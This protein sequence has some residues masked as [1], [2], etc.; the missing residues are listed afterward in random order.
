M[1]A[2][3]VAD[4]GSI[5]N[6]VEQ[7]AGV[8]QSLGQNSQQILNIVE[9]IRDIADRTNLLALNAAIEAARAGE[10]GR[11][12][13][14]VAD[15]VRKL[16]EQTRTSTQEI[17]ATVDS[18][19][20][21]THLAVDKMSGVSR[22]V[23]EGAARA[24]QAGLALDEIDHQIESSVTWANDIAHSTSEQQVV[25]ERFADTVLRIHQLAQRNHGASE[26]SDLAARE[27]IAL[28][29]RLT[30]VVQKFKL[31]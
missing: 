17:S 24:K 16:A 30:E 13:A 26:N 14:V 9:V 23:G 5:A 8:V 25:T 22:S 31:A 3:T 2:G 29:H 6:Q 19:L 12:F 15:E 1:V 18:I 7:S 10:S 27:M 21:Q 28:S 4:M 11:G 20:A